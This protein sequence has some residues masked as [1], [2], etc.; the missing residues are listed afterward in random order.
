MNQLNIRTYT[1]II[2]GLSILAISFAFL[3]AL[4][5]RYKQLTEN[6][7]IAAKIAYNKD[8]MYRHWVSKQGGVYVPITKSTPPNPYLTFIKNRE[9]ITT[10]KLILPF[11]RTTLV[12]S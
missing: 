2:I 3:I 8:L 7:N 5:D 10:D 1:L 6:E 12:I 4:N 9:I 11:H